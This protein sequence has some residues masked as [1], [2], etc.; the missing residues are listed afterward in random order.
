MTNHQPPA[1]PMHIL[2][3]IRQTTFGGGEVYVLN[4]VLALQQVGIRSTVLT[5]QDGAIGQ[6]L[7]EAGVEVVHIPGKQAFDPKLIRKVAA[8]L[9]SRKGD[10]KFSLIHCHG[11]RAASNV[12]LPASWQGIPSIYTVHGWSFHP[13]LG[14]LSGMARRYME[15]LLCRQATQ[16]VCVGEQDARIA[17]EVLN[18]PK[19]T[20]IVNGTPLEKFAAIPS[21]AL[22]QHEQFTFGFI[23]RLTYQ[24]YPELLAQAFAT[25]APAYPQARLV[26]VG[27]GELES[28]VTSILEPVTA[29]GQAML[30]PY[31]SDVAGQLATMDAVVLPSRWEGLSLSLVEAMA[32]GRYCLASNLPNNAEVLTNGITGALFEF[33]VDSL[34]AAMRK[35]LDNPENTLRIAEAGR[36][37]AIAAHSFERVARQN[38][39]L[40][41]RLLASKTTSK[42]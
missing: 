15:K 35:A 39:E 2:H 4:L 37:H 1:G 26:M 34:V 38:L 33:S 17:T 21:L 8:F 13:G 25:I 22:Q 29:A 5:F 23:G 12:L 10:Q 14:K 11:T 20:V 3:A 27:G 19:P 42:P 41:R 28:E 18:L 7:R 24:K 32:A 9:A 36:A 30:L 40:Y 6:Q 31:T 16:V